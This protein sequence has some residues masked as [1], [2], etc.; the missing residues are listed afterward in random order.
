MTSSLPGGGDERVAWVGPTLAAGCVALSQLAYRLLPGGVP[1]ALFAV[2][3]SGAA[4]WFA[5]VGS[6]DARLG[7]F[8][9]GMGVLWLGLAH[10][11][12]GWRRATPPAV[13]PGAFRYVGVLCGVLAF[14]S[15]L[16]A[17]PAPGTEW[18]VPGLT[19]AGLALAVVFADGLRR[20]RRR[21]A[22][23]VAAPEGLLD[24]RLGSPAAGAAAFATALFALASVGL[25]ARSALGPLTA[26]LGALAAFNVFHRHRW[27]AAGLT[28]FVG[29]VLTWTAALV[30]WGAWW[31]ADALARAALGVVCGSLNVRWLSR[32][33]TQQ[34]HDGTAWTTA[35]QLIPLARTVAG[36]MPLAMLSLA[37]ASAL[38]PHTGAPRGAAIVA[39]LLAAAWA[40][41]MA[42]SDPGAS[43]PSRW[44]WALVVAAALLLLTAAPLA[45]GPL[46][47]IPAA[48][49][50]AA[51]TLGLARLVRLVRGGAAGRD[52][53]VWML[54]VLPVVSGMLLARPG[55]DW[56][57][58]LAWAPLGL[59]PVYAVLAARRGCDSRTPLERG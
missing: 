56:T 17:W 47:A 50:A 10:I 25:A 22:A 53:G 2:A 29:V 39:G 11:P 42:R 4:L 48:G 36:A 24:E 7:W 12:G 54:A 44:L 1:E 23:A 5:G 19:A 59:A 13:R 51:L 41:G 30:A 43:A 58:P 26:L 37:L 20:W 38:G 57:V 15:L 35:G 18:A 14:G 55:A 31:D 21:A 8:A 16:K 3:V 32:F 49:G 27:R 40:V 6:G 45:R 33:W 34:L 46:E 28:G 9:A 52:D